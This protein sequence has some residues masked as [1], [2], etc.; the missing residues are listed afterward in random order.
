MG[1]PTR[2]LHDRRRRGQ[3]RQEGHPRAREQDLRPANDVMGELSPHCG[4]QGPGTSRGFI[5]TAPQ[6]GMA[7]LN[8]IGSV[9]V[10]ANASN[11]PSGSFSRSL[12]E[13]T[14]WRTSIPWSVHP[15]WRGYDVGRALVERACEARRASP[16]VARELGRVLQAP[17]FRGM[18]L[19]DGGR[20][21]RRRLRQL[22]DEGRMQA[23]AHAAACVA[24]DEVFCTLRSVPLDVFYWH[25]R[26]YYSASWPPHCGVGGM[27][28]P[29]AVHAWPRSC[30]MVSYV[31]GQ[32]ASTQRLGR[33]GPCGCRVNILF[34]AG[35]GQHRPLGCHQPRLLHALHG[36]VDA[37]GIRLVALRTWGSSPPSG[38]CCSRAWARR[39]APGSVE[40]GRLGPPAP[41]LSELGAFLQVLVKSLG[42]IR[43][44]VSFPLA[45]C[46]HGG[47]QG[48]LTPAATI[49]FG[50]L[51]HNRH[52]CVE[53][54]R[55]AVRIFPESL[56]QIDATSGGVGAVVAPSSWYHFQPGR[57]QGGYMCGIVGY[58]GTRDAEGI[59][60]DGLKHSIPG[61]DLLGGRRG[62]GRHR[63]RVPHGEG[64]K[65]R[66]HAGLAGRRR[67]MRHQA[68][69]VGHAR[70]AVRGERA[71]PHVVRGRDSLGPQRHRRELR[72][73]AR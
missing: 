26:R 35:L 3:L 62:P 31:A 54:I 72:R 12:G 19:G 18:R 42:G 44:T 39:S 30:C 33:E 69:E 17:G 68:H 51:F 38:R 4:R 71:P 16:C 45:V 15:S 22:L 57:K 21:A 61:D 47:Q 28:M 49:V 20:R 53:W 5:R 43:S 2:L 46:V 23:F 64:R 34:A 63:G 65:P 27:S 60:I 36:A 8:S 6:E 59:L 7:N 37:R 1:V 56:R 50:R 70:Q 14:A 67:H 11:K 32:R 48:S 58:V 55:L 24:V 13:E 25:A 40:F 41:R 66:G 29:R 10:A 73:A 9:T 52:C